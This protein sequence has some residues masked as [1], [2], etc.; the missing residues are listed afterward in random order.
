LACGNSF[1]I[2]VMERMLGAEPLTIEQP[3][4]RPLSEIELDLAHMVI[5]KMSDVL[6]SGINAPGGFEASMARPHNA[7]DRPQPD[8][9]VTSEFGVPIRLHVEFGKVTSELALI[10]PQHAFLKTKIIVPKATGQLLKSQEEWQ[11]RLRE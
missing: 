7:E 1:V 11:E 3:F 2:A 6:R 9:T 8:D 10:I 5:D 4:E